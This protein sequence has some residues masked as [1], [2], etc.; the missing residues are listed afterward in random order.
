MPFWIENAFFRISDFLSEKL[1]RPEPALEKWMKAKL[2]SHRGIFDNRQVFENTLAAFDRAEAE[3]I[4]GIEFDI[5][6]TRDLQPV[7]SHDPDCLRIFGENAG[8]GD[9]TL[10]EVK[11]RFP[12]IPPLADVIQRYGGKLHLMAEI[13]PHAVDS[14]RLNEVLSELFS[15]LEPARDFHL[16]SLHP[17][18]F[19]A[20]SFIPPETMVPVAET[21][22]GAVSNM[23]LE[24]GY[25]G[26]AGHYLLLQNDTLK[27]LSRNRLPVGTG[28]INSKNCLYREVNRGITWLFSN[29]AAE[30][31]K[32]MP[33]RSS[34]RKMGGRI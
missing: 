25:G 16:L 22:A 18:L 30:I 15:S 8:I 9:L 31:R 13:K 12:S 6:W 1:P 11:F 19:S 34:F 21:N 27:K 7:V 5:Q 26:M 24:R 4:W 10:K 33:A 20:I 28:F 29:R 14:K 23:V 3:G 32:L 2:I 17:H